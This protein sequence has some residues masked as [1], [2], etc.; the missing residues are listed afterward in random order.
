MTH[1][2]IIIFGIFLLSLS[3]SNPTYKLLINNKIKL[4]LIYQ[5]ILR[6]FIFIF[7]III[8]F[9]GLYIESIP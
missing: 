5:I 9:F 6:I 2:L 8:V 4:K 7:G 3:L 1:W